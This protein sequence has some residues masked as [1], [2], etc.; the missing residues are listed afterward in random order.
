MDT[1]LTKQEYVELKLNIKN[2]ILSIDHEEKIPENITALNFGLYEPYGIELIGAKEY[3]P[4]DDDWACEEDFV[5]SQRDC[6]NIEISEDIYWEDFLNTIVK[7]L[8]EFTVE[9]K[10]LNILKVKHI[11]CGFCDGD[12]VV[13]K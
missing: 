1:K 9:L 11:T 3:D 4:D 12:L 13:I 6:P 8:K 7:I 5:P 2:W 10:D